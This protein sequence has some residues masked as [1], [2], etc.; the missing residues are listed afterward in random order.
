MKVDISVD[1]EDFMDYFNSETFAQ[2]L[3]DEVKGE[4]MKV[5]KRDSKYKAFVAKKAQDTLDGLKI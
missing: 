5:V 3:A 1:L 2:Y 4:I